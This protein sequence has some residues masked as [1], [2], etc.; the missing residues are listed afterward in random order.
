MALAKRPRNNQES[1]FKHADV[2]M[3][4]H[5]P[6]CISRPQLPGMLVSSYPNAV[7]EEGPGLQPAHPCAVQG[8]MRI[9]MLQSCFWIQGC[10]GPDPVVPS[11]LLHCRVSICLPQWSQQV[12][13]PLVGR[14]PAPCLAALDFCWVLA[15]SSSWP[16]KMFA[17]VSPVSELEEPRPQEEASQFWYG[18]CSWCCESGRRAAHLLTRLFHDTRV[19]SYPSSPGKPRG[20]TGHRNLGTGWVGVTD[21]GR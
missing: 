11:L 14:D 5:F 15:R 3:S 12:C 10:H 13:E 16:G 4:T 18:C 21:C 17:W 1:F 6:F 19:A 7:W 20:T 8:S 2:L 9:P